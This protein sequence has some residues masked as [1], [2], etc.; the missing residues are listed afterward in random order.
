[1]G[2]SSRIIV[3]VRIVLKDSFNY[4]IHVQY[5]L[6]YLEGL[7]LLDSSGYEDCFGRICFVI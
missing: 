5:L 1:M 3:D 4:A 2:L 7:I 6:E